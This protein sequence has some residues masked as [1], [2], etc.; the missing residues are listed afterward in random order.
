MKNVNKVYMAAS[1]LGKNKGYDQKQ[2]K[3]P[4]NWAANCEYGEKL[5]PF[6][7]FT[8]DSIIMAFLIGGRGCGGGQ[9]RKRA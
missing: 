1:G 4:L 2:Q 5:L 6:W 9:K 3:C 7:L 8:I